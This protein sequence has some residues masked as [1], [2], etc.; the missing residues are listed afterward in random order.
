MS[1]QPPKKPKQQTTFK[2]AASPIPTPFTAAPPTLEPFLTQLDPSQVYLTHIDRHLPET[3]KQIFL[4]P[5]LLNGTIALLLLYRLY[6]ATPTYWAILQ[7]LLGYHSAATVDTVH[8]TRSDQLW[9]LAKRTLMFLADFLAFRFV[10]V[11]PLTFFL[12]Q[13]CNPVIWRWRLGGFLTDEI[14][15][16]VSRNWG[17]EDLM[18]GVK[19]GEENAFFKT[20]ILPAIERE[21]LRTKTGYLMM[22]QSWDLDFQL[23]LD[24]HTLVKQGQVEMRGLEKMVL[25]FMEGTGWIAWQ[26]ESD[27]DVIEE[28]RKKVV[29][30]KE[31]L[32]KAGKES[33]F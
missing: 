23:M 30:F 21:V 8:T 3:K 18:Q 19:Q 10:G 11:W 20:R 14:V 22:N 4:I 5:V 16:R 2:P 9:I 26:W 1:K 28:R 29:A 27:Y 32:T 7:T 17:A 15:V 31:E 25:V 24:A 6:A 33:L 13:P 12:E